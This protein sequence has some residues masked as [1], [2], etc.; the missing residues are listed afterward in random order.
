VQSGIDWLVAMPLFIVS[1]KYRKETGTLFAPMPI[2]LV[3]GSFKQLGKQY[4]WEVNGY[5]VHTLVQ[6]FA[7]NNPWSC[8]TNLRRSENHRR[9]FAEKQAR[10]A[11]EGKKD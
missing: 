11:A 10:L 2:K 5:W 7:L 3:E 8:N 6:Y 1:Q 9:H 4:L